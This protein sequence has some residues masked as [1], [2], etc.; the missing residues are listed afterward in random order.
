MENSFCVCRQGQLMAQ[1]RKGVGMEG[2]EEGRKITAASCN[3]WCDIWESKNGVSVV[4][5]VN[6]LYRHKCF[7]SQKGV[8]CGI[9]T[10]I[11]SLIPS[12]L[13]QRPV[14]DQWD[15]A[16]GLSTGKGGFG[17]RLTTCFFFLFN[18][19]KKKKALKSYK[20]N[21]FICAFALF[22]KCQI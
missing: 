19:A 9:S 10:T 5:F 21:I 1:F 15:V 8:L 12:S 7:L 22:F 16:H 3:L 14:Y 17:G 20:E 2:D 18:N 6:L 4:R 13:S 11:P